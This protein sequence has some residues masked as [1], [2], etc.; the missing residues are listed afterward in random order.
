MIAQREVQRLAFERQVPE[1]MIELDYVLTWL[2]GALAAPDQ[3]PPLIAKGGT[4]V[5]K[6]YFADWRYSEDLDFTCEQS[7]EPGALEALLRGACAQV[8]SATGLEAELASLEPRYD[9]ASLRTATAYLSYIGPLRRT[10]RPRQVKVDVT[11]DE[12]LATPL[13]TRPLIR[14]FSDEPEPPASVRAYSLD[15]I[16]AEKMRTLLQRTE[17]RDLYDVWRL[18]TE[19]RHELDMEQ[20]PTVFSAKCAH[21][22]VARLHGALPDSREQFGGDGFAR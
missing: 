19:H 20:L 3:S 22:A 21:R 15:E 2:L 7:V 8:A 13:T 4:V 17:P 9:G 14:S 16:C 12:F 5:K 10:R 18:L 11:F 6:V 1:Q